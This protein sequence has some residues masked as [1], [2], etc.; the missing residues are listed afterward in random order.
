MKPTDFNAEHL[1]Q[2]FFNLNAITKALPGE[3]DWN[4]FVQ[5]ADGK[6]Y[7]LKIIFTPMNGGKRRG[8][9]RQHG[10]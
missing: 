5:S 1:L 4:Y 7:I 9:I 10:F 6:K 2:T 8:K 3:L